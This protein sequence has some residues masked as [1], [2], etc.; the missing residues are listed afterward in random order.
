MTDHWLHTKPVLCTVQLR[1]II[2][3]LHRLVIDKN[4]LLAY[5]L[6]CCIACQILS[7]CCDSH[8]SITASPASWAMLARLSDYYMCLHQMHLPLRF[9]ACNL[10]DSNMHLPTRR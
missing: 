3:F 9:V 4:S 2:C 8:S 7:L 5:C 1:L 6:A 10:R